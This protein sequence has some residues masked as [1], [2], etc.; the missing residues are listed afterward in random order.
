MVKGAKRRVRATRK[1]S[2]CLVL[3]DLFA[4]AG[5][6]FVDSHRVMIAIKTPTA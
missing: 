6:V 1:A 2:G 5:E 3:P 4:A